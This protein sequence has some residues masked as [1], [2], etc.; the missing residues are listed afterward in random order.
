LFFVG[1]FLAAYVLSKRLENEDLTVK[2][3]LKAIAHRFLRYWPMYM[4]ALLFFW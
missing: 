2:L 4:I 1:G 3:Y